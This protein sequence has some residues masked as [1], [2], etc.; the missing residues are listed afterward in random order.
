MFRAVSLF[1]STRPAQAP[2]RKWA[3]RGVRP[4]VQVIVRDNNVDQA[5]KALKKGNMKK[6]VDY[7]KRLAKAAKE[8]A[9]NE[10][11]TLR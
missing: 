3:N 6:A 4:I 11:K 2:Q 5:L 10:A 7:R 1:A 8:L 9:E